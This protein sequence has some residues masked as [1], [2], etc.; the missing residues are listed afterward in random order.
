MLSFVPCAQDVIA[1]VPPHW[2]DGIKAEYGSRFSG[3]VRI[4]A[5]G[6][7]LYYIF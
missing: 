1:A 5:E 6:L 3:A 7:T 2:N 4:A